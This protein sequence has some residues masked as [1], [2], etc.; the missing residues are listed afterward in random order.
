M[1]IF[2]PSRADMRRKALF[3]V[4]VLSLLINPGFT[5]RYK[6]NHI[7]AK[8]FNGTTT[9]RFQ[10]WVGNKPLK[11]FEE[12]YINS[13]GEP[14]VVNKFK[15]YVSHISLTVAGNKEINLPDKYFLVNEEDSTSKEI[16]LPANGISAISFTIGVDSARNVSG[17]QTGA[18]DPMNAMFWTWNSGYVFAKL[19]GQSDSSHAPVHSFS[20]HVG[21][22]RQQENA[23]QKIQLVVDKN[24]GADN[25]I[26]IINADILK[27]F[28][29][30]QPLK[31]S[32]TPICHQPGKLAMQIAANYS[33]MFSV[34]P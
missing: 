12:T 32:Q 24:S 3:I 10:H 15:Y 25:N 8:H 29:G 28:D 27:W 19:E 7:L 31:I 2:M 5:A 1:F 13:F 18:L 17:V 21:G 30:R 4:I 9:V 14:F 22:F 33:T 20:W 16:V 23:L 34:A 11:L 6:A 26:I